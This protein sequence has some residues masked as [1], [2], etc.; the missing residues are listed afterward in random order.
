MGVGED[1]A[2][3]IDA[4]LAT[5]TSGTDLFVGDM[6]PDPDLCTALIE[7]P[8]SP[9]LETLGPDGPPAVILPRVQV[10]T[11]AGGGATAYP[12]AKERARDVYDVLV[13]I[14]N[15]NVNGNAHFR[16]APLQEPYLL[17]RDE[18]ERVV[19]AFGV[20]VWRVAE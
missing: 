15:E 3:A 11:R 7:T 12:D 5:H 8:G 19:F 1:L 10:Q 13:A 4:A 6:P 16:A 14:T 20:E 18:S 9:P 2:V 17:H